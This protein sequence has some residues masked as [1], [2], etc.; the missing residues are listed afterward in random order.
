MLRSV[1]SVVAG[2][3]LGSVIIL[4]VEMTDHALFP[5]PPGLDPANSESLK[6]IPAGA[7]GAVIMAWFAGAFGGGVVA[8]LIARRWAPAAWVV[9]A[10]ILLLAGATMAQIPHPLWMIVGA[11]AATGLGGYLSVRLTNGYYGRPS[12][13]GA[14]PLL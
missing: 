6:N 2:V 11:I 4:I 12:S 13:G 3:L 5:P 7:L 10:T 9:A 8:S 1:L 14:K